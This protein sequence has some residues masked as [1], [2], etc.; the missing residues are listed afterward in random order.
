MNDLS[1]FI[2]RLTGSIFGI[3]ILLFI[4]VLFV[5]GILM[6]LFVV[7]I[8]RRITRVD[9]L[10]HSHC[11]TLETEALMHTKLL[12]DIRNSLQ[13]MEAV[14]IEVEQQPEPE[15]T[16]PPVPQSIGPRRHQIRQS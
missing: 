6:P 16:L 10:L 13:S 11:H 1:D 12:A 8:H 3:A 5:A 2:A 14:G 9:T 15:Y 4:L 7:A